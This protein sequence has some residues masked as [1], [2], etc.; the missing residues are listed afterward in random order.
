M[1]E[2]PRRDCEIE[3]AA[4]QLEAAAA[5]QREQARQ[6]KELIL[7]VERMTADVRQHARANATTVAHSP[8]TQARPGPERSVRTARNATAWS[9][10]GAVG[11]IGLAMVAAIMF[12]D[13]VGGIETELRQF[14][15]GASRSVVED[16]SGRIADCGPRTAATYHAW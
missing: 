12:T 14:C 6:V 11:A 7:R 16:A 4:S 5:L 13:V 2:F 8:A 15:E 9:V 1:F 10:A 3:T